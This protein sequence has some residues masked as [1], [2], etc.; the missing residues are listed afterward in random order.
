MMALPIESMRLDIMITEKAEKR[1]AVERLPAATTSQ[2]ILKD[3]L[4][5]A[6]GVKE[7]LDP[8]LGKANLSR[9]RV[10]QNLA[11]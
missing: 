2:Q 4:L 7:K 11:S 8:D 5:M 10:M 1:A 6:L 3:T 9:N